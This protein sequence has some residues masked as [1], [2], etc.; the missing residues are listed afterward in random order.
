MSSAFA[1]HPANGKG[2]ERVLGGWPEASNDDP[3]RRAVA[4]FTD[5]LNAKGVRL[6]SVIDKAAEARQ[7]GLEL[8]DIALVLFGNPKAGTPV[9]VASPLSA[10]DLSLKVVVWADG[11]QAKVSSPTARRRYRRTAPFPGDQDG[12][13]RRSACGVRPVN[14]PNLI[15]NP[16]SPASAPRSVR[17]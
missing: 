5:L 17:R 2:Q 11:Q 15:D 1:V 10:L 6:L 13:P 8:R 16:L 14:E 12:H 9:V 3:H 7:V 4:C